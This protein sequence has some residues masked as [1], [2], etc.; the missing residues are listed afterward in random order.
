L[1]LE[2][3]LPLAGTDDG[4]PDLADYV[5]HRAYQ[6]SFIYGGTFSLPTEGQQITIDRF[7]LDDAG[8]FRSFPDAMIS[9]DQQWLDQ[10]VSDPPDGLVTLLAST[11]RPVGVALAQREPLYSRYSRI[12]LHLLFL[13]LSG[14][15]FFG[16]ASVR[17]RKVRAARNAGSPGRIRQVA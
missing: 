12:V 13:L 3:L 6:E 9:F 1:T 10:I 17:L 16:R 8:Q 15:P 11:D 14:L 7:E 5:M 2:A 4:L